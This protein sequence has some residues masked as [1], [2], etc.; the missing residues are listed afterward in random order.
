MQHSRHLVLQY[1]SCKDKDVRIHMEDALI[2]LFRANDTERAAIS[3]RRRAEDGS[4]DYM[5]MSS[6]SGLLGLGG[7]RLS[8]GSQHGNGN[9]LSGSIHGG[10]SNTISTNNN[11][12]NSRHGTVVN[13]RR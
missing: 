11:N 6:L 7:D 5:S 2:A 3:E 13:V 1:L 10:H 12:N 8:G 4:N 9:S